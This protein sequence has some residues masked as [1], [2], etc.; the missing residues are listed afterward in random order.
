MRGKWAQ[1]IVPRGF[2][3]I[4]TDRLA[5][6]E[7]PGGCG[8]NHRKVR[9]Q[10]EIIWLRENDFDLVVSLLGS[11]HNL[12]HYE[13]LGVG[14]AAGVVAYCGSGVSACHDLLAM[15][16][17]G[18]GRGRLYVGSWSQ[19]SATGRPAATG[20]EPDRDD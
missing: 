13:E 9:R 8:T 4:I 17:A 2:K 1:G 3:W 18:L 6:C 20:G 7:R 16:H 19:W 10:E 5:V 15:E 11:E 12:A 14:E